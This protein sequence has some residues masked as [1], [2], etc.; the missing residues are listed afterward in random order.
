MHC[1][2]LCFGPTLWI[3]LF[4]LSCLSCD[5]SPKHETKTP[6]IVRISDW[7]FLV[8]TLLCLLATIINHFIWLTFFVWVGSK[9]SCL[10][11]RTYSEETW[12]CLVLANVGAEMGGGCLWK[13]LHLQ[14]DLCPAFKQISSF[15]CVAS[16]NW[17]VCLS[18]SLSTKQK[19]YCSPI[20]LLTVQDEK[21]CLLSVKQLLTWSGNNPDQQTPHNST[22]YA[23]LEDV[24]SDEI[25]AWSLDMDVMFCGY[26]FITDFQ[27]ALECDIKS[28]AYSSVRQM[29]GA[30]SQ[31]VRSWWQQLCSFSAD[32]R[33]TL[34]TW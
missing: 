21:L 4:C 27:F 31:R 34:G 24:L 5:I 28:E 23:T 7:S 15:L 30:D 13:T 12:G 26:E 1:R 8:K 32:S 3:W 25:H 29:F 10:P 19:K 6:F 17:F 14:K 18:I 22:I 33:V 16:R 20:L 9:A 11:T 2:Q